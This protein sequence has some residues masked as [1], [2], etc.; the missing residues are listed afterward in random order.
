M[1]LDF[2]QMTDAQKK[3]FE[4]GNP[5]WAFV[6]RGWTMDDTISLLWHEGGNDGFVN[7]T[8]EENG[9]VVKSRYNFTK[10]MWLPESI[11]VPK[12]EEE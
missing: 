11:D 6:D 12:E 1:T 9:T 10:E 7:Y 2:T 5:M 8:I 4:L 3:V